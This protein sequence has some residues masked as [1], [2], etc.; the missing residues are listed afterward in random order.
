MN[1]L[2]VFMTSSSALIVSAVHCVA[3]VQFENR[4][5]LHCVDDLA[6]NLF[7]KLPKVPSLREVLYLRL[8]ILYI[9]VFSLSCGKF[10]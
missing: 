4:T 3:R 2:D 5:L 6:G 7:R 8:S 1:H 10:S 9:A